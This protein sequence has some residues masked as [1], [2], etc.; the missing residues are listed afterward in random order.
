MGLYYDT[1][2]YGFQF[3]RISR[4]IFHIFHIFHFIFA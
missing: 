4:L 3:R 1:L 2:S